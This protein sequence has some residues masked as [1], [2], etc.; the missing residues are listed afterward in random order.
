MSLIRLFLNTA[1]ETSRL[2]PVWAI[3]F[4]TIYVFED[5]RCLENIIALQMIE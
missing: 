2:I 1:S 4:Q 3:K 5:V